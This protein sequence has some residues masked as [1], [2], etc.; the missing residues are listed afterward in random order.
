MELVTSR[1]AYGEVPSADGYVVRELF[2]RH[3]LGAPGSRLRR[4]TKLADHVPDMLA[5]A[6]AGCRAPT[7][8]TSSG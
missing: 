3:A 8:S 5:M 6:P 1:F 2:Y 4:F 7:S